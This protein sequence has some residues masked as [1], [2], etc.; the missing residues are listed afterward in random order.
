MH[1]EHSRPLAFTFINALFLQNLS[2]VPNRLA[3]PS[4]A[5]LTVSSQP[6]SGVFFARA[7]VA[8]TDPR[9]VCLGCEEL[10]KLC[11]FT[12]KSS[13]HRGMSTL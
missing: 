13:L 11:P 4:P 12:H 10:E 3:L 7:R 1:V 9:Q 5:T 6:C 2:L 8:E